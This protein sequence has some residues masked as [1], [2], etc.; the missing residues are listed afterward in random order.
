[1]SE[2][3][4][5]VVWSTRRYLLVE[6]T[7]S[8]SVMDLDAGDEPIATYPKDEVGFAQAEA[9]FRSLRLGSFS[10][11][12]PYQVVLTAVIILGLV[13]WVVAGAIETS[14]FVGLAGGTF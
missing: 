6:R 4:P 5:R 11:A 12:T 7:D 9:R 14:L 13:V 1:M 10:K 3:T 8:Y 2:D